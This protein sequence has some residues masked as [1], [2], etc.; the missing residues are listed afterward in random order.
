MTLKTW[1]LAAPM[2]IS[3]LASAAFAGHIKAR[4]SA[5]GREVMIQLDEDHIPLRVFIYPNRMVSIADFIE[6]RYTN[7]CFTG[8]LAGMQWM[9]E[10]LVNNVGADGRRATAQLYQV[11]I[12]RDRTYQITV[13]LNGKREKFEFPFCP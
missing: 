9:V 11:R 6:G 10:G 13:G 12:A 2:A 5:T 7:A 3:L 4:E 8:T 1:S